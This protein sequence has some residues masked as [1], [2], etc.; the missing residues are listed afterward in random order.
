MDAIV[1]LPPEQ[2]DKWIEC[3]NMGQKIIIHRLSN[4]T[5][6]VQLVQVV[7]DNRP[8]RRFAYNLLPI[9]LFASMLPAREKVV[10]NNLI[11]TIEREA[12]EGRNSAKIDTILNAL[13]SVLARNVVY[14]S[15]LIE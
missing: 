4:I 11:A 12:V 13:K 9:D 10:Y 2:V 14:I 15:E 5:N 3:I 6:K 7:I 1:Y 8:N